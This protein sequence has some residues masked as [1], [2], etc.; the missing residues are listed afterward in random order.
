M[1]CHQG[2]WI[3]RKVLYYGSGTITWL[4]PDG[5]AHSV[6]EKTAENYGSNQITLEN[7]GTESVPINIKATMNSDNGY[8]A[9]YPGRPVLPD[10]ETGGGRRKAL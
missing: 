9:V 7:N 5:V 3:W 10:R 4:I 6:A 8:I 2:G 1:R